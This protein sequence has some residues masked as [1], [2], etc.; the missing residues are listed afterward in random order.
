MRNTLMTLIFVHFLFNN[1][2]GSVNSNCDCGPKAKESERELI[3][4][5]KR[6]A[7][8]YNSI[9]HIRYKRWVTGWSSASFIGDDLIITAR[10]SVGKKLGLA[11]KWIEI[12]LPESPSTCVKL[13]K[14]D[15]KIIEMGDDLKGDIALVKI[16]NS[17]LQNR[18]KHSSLVCA[19]TSA[20]EALHNTKAIVHLTGFPCDKNGAL[21]DKSLP[22]NELVFTLDGKAQNVFCAYGIYTCTGDS[23]APLWY[24]KDGVYYIIG[25]HH[26]GGKDASF[27]AELNMSLLINDDVINWINSNK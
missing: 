24:E 22:A 14:R 8:P 25:V 11:T 10:H 23:G 15:F 16:L 5:L 13:S 26:G 19:N 6:Q 21:I 17:E 2:I 9:V 1:S 18:I 7:K 4:S 20:I 12:Y 3:D 27:D